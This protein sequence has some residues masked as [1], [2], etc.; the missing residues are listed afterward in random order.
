ML[1][2]DILK[3]FV[4]NCLLTANKI[5]LAAKLLSQNNS[6]THADCFHFVLTQHCSVLL[7]YA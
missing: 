5:V 7:T 6:T 1:R 4:L 2:Y 3:Q